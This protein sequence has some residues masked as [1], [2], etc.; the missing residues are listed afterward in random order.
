MQHLNKLINGIFTCECSQTYVHPSLLLIGIAS[1]LVQGPGIVYDQP[2]SWGIV[3]H[4]QR[5]NRNKAK[6]R[7]HPENTHRRGKYH[8]MAVRLVY[9]LTGLDSAVSAYKQKNIFSCLVKSNPVKMETSSTAILLPTL[10]GLCSLPHLLLG[11]FGWRFWRALGKAR[12]TRIAVWGQ[13]PWQSKNATMGPIKHDKT[14]DK[15]TTSLRIFRR[16]NFPQFFC[17]KCCCCC[18]CW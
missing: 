14:R 5:R 4:F 18:C 11:P 7:P 16:K 17:V 12:Q 2:D 10:D 15:K 9:S 1:A 3:I 8:S 6:G 13:K